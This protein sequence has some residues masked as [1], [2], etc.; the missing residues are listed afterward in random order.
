MG[1][2]KGNEK[3]PDLEKIYPK[4]YWGQNNDIIFHP[5][6]RELHTVLAHLCHM[7]G[8]IHSFKVL[9]PFPEMFIHLSKGV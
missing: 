8:F 6:H 9:P 2:R 1:A 7:T 4:E 5:F 3:R